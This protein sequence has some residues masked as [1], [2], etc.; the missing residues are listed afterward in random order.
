MNRRTPDLLLG[1]MGPACLAALACACGGNGEEEDAQT[2]QVSDP[3]EDRQDETGP[4]AEEVTQPD[5]NGR[6]E[7]LDGID[8]LYLWGTRHEMGYAEGSLVCGRATAMMRD[9]ILDYVVPN[10]GYTYGTL[11]GLVALIYSFPAGDEAELEGLM[12]GMKDNCPPEDL[13]VESPNLETGSGG[14]REM[15][16][17]D[18][19]TAHALADW[20]CS[21]LTVWGDASATGGTL[22]ARNLDFY[23][24]DGGVILDSHIVKLYSSEEEGGARWMSISFPGLIG[25]ISCFTE[26][27]AGLTI[28]NSNGLDPS[29]AGGHV[30]RMLAARVALT[31]SQL[32]SDRIQAAEDVLEALS[33]QIGNNFHLSFPCSTGTCVGGAVF[34][35]DGNETHADGQVTV[36]M[37]GEYDGGLDTDQAI[38]CTNHYMKRV[39][40]PSSGG[41]VSRFE[42]M[43]TG[44]ND[45][46]ASGGLDA[47]GA[48]ALMSATAA[49][50]STPTIHTVIMD[51]AAMQLHLYIPPDVSMEAPAA[52][53]VVLDFDP[54]F[55]TLP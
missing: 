42:T 32:A 33:Q 20:A 19:K 41:S 11:L 34:E 26:D 43:V 55:S 50:N 12:Q 52:D 4:D 16:L 18:L 46:L 47:A 25:C 8:V 24:D 13:I 39:A 22:H 45:A 31:A 17:D 5:V 40:P 38:V 15:T 9:Y 2:D 54:L 21:S 30:P 48:L 49:I 53:P 44:I 1:F 37:P 10:S 14:S 23:E 36:R 6:I 51:S 7:H 27:G 35:Y 28:H 3:A 29:E